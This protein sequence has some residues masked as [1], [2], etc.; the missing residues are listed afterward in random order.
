MAIMR[1]FILIK[2]DYTAEF[3]VSQIK[4][5]NEWMKSHIYFHALSVQMCNSWR[6]KSTL[7]I[8]GSSKVCYFLSWFYNCVLAYLDLDGSSYG[9]FGLTETEQAREEPSEESPEETEEE[10]AMAA[11][12]VGQSET[13]ALNGSFST[14]ILS[15]NLF[16]TITKTV[17]LKTWNG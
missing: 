4:F 16:I 12:A 11:Q 2:W 15:N 14:N 8:N 5:N 7:L 10:R 13:A 17:S 6:I 1:L 3:I 9:F